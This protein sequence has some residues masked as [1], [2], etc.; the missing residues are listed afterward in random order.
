[1]LKLGAELE[2]RD[3]DTQPLSEKELAELIGARDYNRF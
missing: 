1:L 2:S 3:L